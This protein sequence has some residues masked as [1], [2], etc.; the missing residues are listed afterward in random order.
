[1]RENGREW[2][3]D[4]QAAEIARTG[5]QSL[6]VGYTQV[7]GYYI[8]V[9]KPNLP[10]V[11]ADYVRKQ[12][13][14]GGERFVTEQ[15][16][17]FEEEMRSAEER[18]R[19]REAYL[20]ETV[21]QKLLSSAADIHR[22]A[23]E[24]AVL[25]VLLS[26]AETAL[27]PGYTAPE[28]TDSDLIRITQG[29]HP[30]VEDALGRS[31]VPNDIVW[32]CSSDRL[33]IITG[34]NMAG[35]STYIR[36]NALI[37]ILAQMG[38]YVPAEQASIG[39]ADRIFARIGFRDDIAA[40]QSTFMVEMTET[41]E[42]L[43]SLTPRSLVVLD[44]IGRGTST[45]DGLSLA[46]AVAERLCRAGARTVFA[47]HF[48]ELT[49]LADQTEGVKNF[50]VAVQRRKDKI[51]FLHRIMP[52]GSDDSYGLYVARIAGIPEQ[53]VRRAQELLALLE[54]QARVKEKIARRL[55]EEQEGSLFSVQAETLPQIVRTEMA[56]LD[57]VR[58]ELANLDL[59]T[60]TPLEALAKLAEW[61][62]RLRDGGN[63]DSQP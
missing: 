37:V 20:V 21:R 58:D 47:T 25:D 6:K 48:H 22:Y 44:E 32:N 42:I 34:P 10:L 4:F 36:Q 52:G 43:N 14:A 50:N 59:N 39:V 41:A 15:L 60:M 30:V 18:M 9:S 54:M 40:G 12:T 56:V 23:D 55:A 5:I 13:I 7:F 17:R 35:K 11:P 63:T 2:L 26:L 8:E 16:A 19:E 51:V 27:R 3:R 46:W 45:F 24:V 49:A 38:S 29:R 28:I 31:F 1:M 61:K 57:E 62:R 33:L 53:V